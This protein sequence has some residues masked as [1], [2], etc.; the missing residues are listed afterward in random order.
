MKKTLDRFNWTAV[1]TAVLFS[2]C[3]VQCAKDDKEESPTPTNPV[4]PKTRFVADWNCSEVSRRDP[5]A[6]Q[7]QVHML[8]GTGDSLVM[9]NCYA[10][11]FANKAKLIVYGDSL[12]F[13]PANQQIA[14]GIFL[15]NGK[16]KLINSSTIKMTYIIDDGNPIKD[17]VDATFTK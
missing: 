2:L 16:G 4:D 3:F 14:S 17:T 11:G 10:V 8:N 7:F 1:I 5:P 9:E 6:G 13:A 15:L 12:K